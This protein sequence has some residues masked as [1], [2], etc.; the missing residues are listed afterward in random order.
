MRKSATYSIEAHRD[1]V[2]I[3]PW[4]S[5]MF[6]I[7]ASAI[8]KIGNTWRSKSVWAFKSVAN[9]LKARA[10]SRIRAIVRVQILSL[11]KEIQLTL[12]P[13]SGPHRAPLS[14]S[15][16]LLL[17]RREKESIDKNIRYT[18]STLYSEPTLSAHKSAE[19]Q[20]RR[21]GYNRYPLNPR[22]VARSST[23]G[24]IAGVT[25]AT[26]DPICIHRSWNIQGPRR[27]PSFTEFIATAERNNR[28]FFF[29]S[30]PINT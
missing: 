17:L 19:R 4:F 7:R 3:G 24:W 14:K 20:K 23:A 18:E 15:N 12:D 30:S 5:K 22:D 1:I 28:P 26:A 10:N 27:L 6:R 25:P 21:G 13:I 2:T 9:A 29:F 8:L 16:L 11:Q